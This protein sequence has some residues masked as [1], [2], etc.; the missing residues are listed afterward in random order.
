[1][2]RFFSFFGF[3]LLC[4]TGCMNFDY[5]G[6]KFDPRP[7]SSP[8]TF[9]EERE[10]IPPDTYRIIGRG[11]LTGPARYDSYDRR[12]K[13]CSVARERG[14]DAVCIVDTRIIPVGYYPQAKGEF[15]GPSTISTNRESTDEIGEPLQ[16]D[17]FGE[18]DDGSRSRKKRV[19]YDFEIKLLL[20]KKSA[21]F[22]EAM[23]TRKGFL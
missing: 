21:D 4:C 8:V 11:T 3:L 9:F 23:K 16:T 19:R 5:V 14:A 6:Q 17:S 1:M 15:A 22:D 20:L 18:K 13:M 7:D 10:K 2:I 12:Q